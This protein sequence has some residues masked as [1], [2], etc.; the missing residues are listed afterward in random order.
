[1]SPLDAPWLVIENSRDPGELITLTAGGAKYALV[2][3]RADLAASFLLGLDDQVDLT[4]ST[5]ESWVLKETYLTA[6]SVLGA[7]HVLF[8]YVRGGQ[9]AQAAPVERVAEFLRSRSVPGN[10]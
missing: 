6:A 1:V 10:N 5:L 3:T 4:V 2:F 9:Q 7:T 8:D